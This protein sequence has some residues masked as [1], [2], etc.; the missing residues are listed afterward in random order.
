MFH[1]Q[2]VSRNKEKVLKSLTTNTGFIRLF[3]ATSSLGC[4]INASDVMFVVHFGPSFGLAD[5]CQQIGRA[6]RNSPHLCHAI[7]YIYPL[8]KSSLS[9]DMKDYI[10]SCKKGCLRTA[11][12]TPFNEDNKTILPSSVGHLCCS[13]CSESCKCEVGNCQRKYLH[14]QLFVDNECN[15]E[16]ANANAPFRTVETDEKDLVKDLLNQYMTSLSLPNEALLFVPSSYVSGLTDN[17]ISSILSHLPFIRSVKDILFHTNVVDKQVADEV[18]LI[19][20]EV[21]DDIPTVKPVEIDLNLDLTNLDLSDT[22]FSFNEDFD[23]D[24]ME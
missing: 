24:E 6:G 10:N 12:F 7:L 17:I 23:S 1:A 2:T 4:G 18:L 3:I 20:S 21:F 9:E 19:V 14:E 8:K 16:T 15:S 5:Y 22:D 13:Y 11:L